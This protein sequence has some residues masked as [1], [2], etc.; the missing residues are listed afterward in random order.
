MGPMTSSLGCSEIRRRQGRGK[1]AS[2]RA[3]STTLGGPVTESQS[4]FAQVLTEVSH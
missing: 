4:C 2:V 3:Y 1:V